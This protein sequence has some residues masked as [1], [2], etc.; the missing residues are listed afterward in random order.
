VTLELAPKVGTGTP[1]TLDEAKK[2]G[3]ERDKGTK[4]ETETLKDGWLVKYQATGS[5]GESFYLTVRRSIGG[6][7]YVCHTSV[8]FESLRDGAAM[9]CKSLR[10]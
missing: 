4:I 7:D 3:T 2:Q 1:A 9:A 5:L 6:K 10:P 8:G